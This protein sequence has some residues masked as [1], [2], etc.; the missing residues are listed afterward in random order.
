MTGMTNNYN[1][2]LLTCQPRWATPRTSRPTLGG[3]VAQISAAL[4]QPFMP[5]QR[6]VADVAFEVDPETGLLVY[7]EIVLTVPRQSGKTTLT[8]SLMTHRC[9]AMGTNQRVFYTAQ[10]GKDARQKWEDDHVPVLEQSP[11]SSLFNVRK[12]NGSEAL[13]WVNGSIWGLLASTESS[14]HGGQ[15][16]CTVIDEAFAQKDARIEQSQK[17]AMVTRP[18]PQLWVVSTMGTDDSL[19]LN[20]KVEQGRLRAA[21]GETSSVAFFEWSA[22]EDADPGDPATWWACMPAL[23]YTVSE[24][25]IRYNFD[26]M[27]ESEFRRAFLNQ[28]QSKDASAPWQ[29][30]GEDIWLSC[31]D[32]NSQIVN[33][34]TI[35]IDVTP[36]RSMTSICAAGMRRDGLAHVEVVANRPGTSWVMDWFKENNRVSR[37]K[38]V[39][40]DPVSGAYSLVP[41]LRAAGLKIVEVSPRNV[42]AGC[43]KFFDLVTSN[44]LRHLDQVPLST[45]VAGAKKRI[46]GDSWAWAR[47]DTSIDVSPLVACTLALYWHTNPES[48]Q[49]VPQIVDPWSLNDD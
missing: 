21:A 32:N 23:G 22:P 9:I 42:A 20:E 18:Q 40:I 19:Y 37:Y 10:S 14:G 36:S 17:P 1:N 16:D 4:G 3:K 26:S 5:W 46:L 6:H 49:G 27:K 34:P 7:R 28:R 41:D 48:V 2:S 39:V 29:V 31:A 33:T 43:G 15:S 25:T 11:F 45:A 30:I 8:L 47:R 38:E 24:E 35:A 44:R 13:R 12:T